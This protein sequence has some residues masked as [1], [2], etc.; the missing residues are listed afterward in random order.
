MP[1]IPIPNYIISRCWL[2]YTLSIERTHRIC[3]CKII[4]YGIHWRQVSN[5]KLSSSSRRWL[6]GKTMAGYTRGPAKADKFWSARGVFSR[7][8]EYSALYIVHVRKITW[9]YMSD[10]SIESKMV[11]LFLLVRIINSI[12]NIQYYLYK[13]YIAQSTWST[14]IIV[15]FEY[16]RYSLFSYEI[17]IHIM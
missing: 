8:K 5:R 2:Y 4:I 6:S 1:K 15:C 9:K 16:I 10:F 17:Y 11:I 7:W 14:N 12:Y 13:K 3:A